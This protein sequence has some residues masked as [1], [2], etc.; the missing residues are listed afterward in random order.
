M[1]GHFGNRCFPLISLWMFAIQQNGF[2]GTDR[3][4]Q[5]DVA[6]S[7]LKCSECAKGPAQRQS[8]RVEGSRFNL[9]ILR[10]KDRQKAL[11]SE[12]S[13]S[14]SPALRLNTVF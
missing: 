6:L 13:P 1:A 7:F 5:R 8:G 14:K 12:R 9:Y 10:L 11:I 2:A 4:G 3:S